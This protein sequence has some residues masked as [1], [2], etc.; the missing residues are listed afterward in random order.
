MKRCQEE[1]GRE[2]KEWKERRT[3][4]IYCTRNKKEIDFKMNQGS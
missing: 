1:K 2:S 3:H 4:I